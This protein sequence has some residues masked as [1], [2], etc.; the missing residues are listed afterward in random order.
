MKISLHYNRHEQ[1]LEN[2]S[3]FKREFYLTSKKYPRDK[4]ILETA[5]W[6][7]LAGETR[8]FNLVRKANSLS[9]LVSGYLPRKMRWKLRGRATV[10]RQVIYATL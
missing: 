9:A 8:K 3:P 7:K 4:D 2:H 10:D 6:N 1:I 5:T